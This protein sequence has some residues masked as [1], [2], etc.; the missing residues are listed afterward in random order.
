MNNY[1]YFLIRLLD[2]MINIDELI[3]KINNR[4]DKK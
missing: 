1:I 2:I 3:K 4:I